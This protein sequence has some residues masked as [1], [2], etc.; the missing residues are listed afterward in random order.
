[1]IEGLE[2]LQADAGAAIAFALVLAAVVSL[3]RAVHAARNRRKPVF[4]GAATARLRAMVE[5]RRRSIRN[6]FFAND[7][8]AAPFDR[9]TRA[10]VYRLADPEHG[11]GTLGAGPPQ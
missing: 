10:W 5:T 2:M 11:D 3:G 6:Y 8:E 7:A 9:A 4:D 1:M